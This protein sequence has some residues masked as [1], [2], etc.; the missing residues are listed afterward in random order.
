MRFLY[1][2]NAGDFG[3]NAFLCVYLEKQQL[4]ILFYHKA[5]NQT[6]LFIILY[7]KMPQKWRWNSRT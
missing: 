4:Y 5:Q 7:V 3:L 1:L 6:H 2:K